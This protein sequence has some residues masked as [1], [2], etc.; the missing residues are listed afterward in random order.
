MKGTENKGNCR[1]SKGSSKFLIR[2]YA[3]EF[4]GSF[5]LN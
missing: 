1:M 2:E 5:S 4:R 3:G